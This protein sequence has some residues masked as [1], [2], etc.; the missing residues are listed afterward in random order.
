MG[1]QD[2]IQK[3]AQLE[4]S[5]QDLNIQLAND[6]EMVRE[7]S[8]ELDKLISEI[9]VKQEEKNKIDPQFQQKL[10]QEKDLERRLHTAEQRR[11]ELYAKQGRGNQFNDRQARD[12]WIQKE[13]KTLNRG[14]KDKE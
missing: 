12:E 6:Q 2:M 8:E 7:A 11:K 14:I 9:T 1:R 4:L 5:V 13:L 3:K 10:N